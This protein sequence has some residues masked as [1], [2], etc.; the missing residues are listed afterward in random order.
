M[1]AQQRSGREGAA[2]WFYDEVADDIIER[3]GFMRAEPKDALLIGAGLEPVQAALPGCNFTHGSLDLDEERPLPVGPF[4][5]IVSSGRFDKIND[6]PGAMLHAR[7][8]LKEG[9]LL[10]AS[11]PGAGSLPRLRSAMLT[12]DGE[13]AAPRIHP[14]I[15]AQAGAGLLQRAGFKRQVAD[16]LPLNLSYSSLNRLVSDL[17]D[18]GLGN[19]LRLPG[20][21]LGKAQ[22][23][24][25]KAAFLADADENGRVI[26]T[27][28]VLTLTGWR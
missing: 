13:R 2:R 25:A 21:P 6:L 27:I 23:D 3:L 19:A 5:L 10:I 9:G 20:P 16:S 24:K 17:R 8:A 28:E 4:D 26:E 12:A 1:R 14:Q 22:Y 7:A 15:D 11:L 18:Q